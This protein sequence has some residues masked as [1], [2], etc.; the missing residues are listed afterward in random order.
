LLFE[1]E[2]S[3]IKVLR[4]WDCTFWRAR[5]IAKSDYYRRHVCLSFRPSVRFSV[6]SHGTARLPLDE[7]SWNL[8]FQ[9]FSK[10]YRNISSFVKIWQE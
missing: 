5:K 10:L 1:A 6:H 3:A 2:F 8:V 7:Y 9:Y 4:N